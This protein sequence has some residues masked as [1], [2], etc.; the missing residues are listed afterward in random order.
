M[1]CALYP[2][3][4]ETY[5]YYAAC[6]LNYQCPCVCINQFNDFLKR[7]TVL[8][9]KLIKNIDLELHFLSANSKE[10]NEN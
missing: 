9:K 2:H 8:E 1:L 7:T 10:G 6:S 5:K 4:V 3:I